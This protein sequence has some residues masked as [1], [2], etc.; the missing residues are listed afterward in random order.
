MET[1]TTWPGEEIVNMDYAFAA[2]KLA[3]DRAM[4]RKYLKEKKDTIERPG[5]FDNTDD[6]K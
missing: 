5:K 3:Q 4:S 2:M 6:A 1:A